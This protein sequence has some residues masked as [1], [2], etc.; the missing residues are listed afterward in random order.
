MCRFVSFSKET[1]FLSARTN[2]CQP[3]RRKTR[4]HGA[5]RTRLVTKTNAQRNSFRPKIVQH[6]WRH[7]PKIR[8]VLLCARRKRAIRRLSFEF[9]HVN[10]VPLNSSF[11]FIEISLKPI[12][13]DSY[14]FSWRCVPVVIKNQWE[15]E[16]TWHFDLNS[17]HVCFQ[18]NRIWPSL[19]FQSENCVSANHFSN[20]SI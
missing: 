18:Y 5:S 8:I 9:F 16:Q 19:Y 11:W 4:A 20:V 12:Y 3:P 15:C 6:R 14:F 2:V 7:A 10:R 1:N 17:S 13:F